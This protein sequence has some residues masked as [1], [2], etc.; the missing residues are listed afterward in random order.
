MTAAV[1]RPPVSAQCPSCRLHALV[2]VYL[3]R[4]DNGLW[5]QVEGPESDTVVQIDT[6]PTCG[7]A[8]FDPGELDTL[9]KADAD[10]DEERSLESA[11]EDA[12]SGGASRGERR[13]PRGC[14][15]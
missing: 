1:D 5:K 10:A 13:C 14:S 4:R 8:F 11:L 6:C 7:G 9:A 2:A 12:D 15:T 3:E